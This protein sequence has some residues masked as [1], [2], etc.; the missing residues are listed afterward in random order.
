MAMDWPMYNPRYLG[1]RSCEMQ[2]EGSTV[3]T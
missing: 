3:L 1:G 2:E